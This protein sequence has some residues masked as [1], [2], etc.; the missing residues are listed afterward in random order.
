M[1]FTDLN[2]EERRKRVVNSKIF[3]NTFY[4][5]SEIHINNF[6]VDKIR[7]QYVSEGIGIV[8]NNKV[9]SFWFDIKIIK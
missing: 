9:D 5:G 3:I 1:E 8:I 2:H 4:T 6:Y 7:N